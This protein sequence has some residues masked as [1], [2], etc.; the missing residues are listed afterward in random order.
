MYAK[1]QQISVLL[2]CLGNI[3]R[4]PMAEG[5]LR[6]AAERAGLDIRVDSAGTAA[7]H[8]GDPPD[9]RAVATAKAHG[10]NISSLR[11]RQLIDRD[12]ESFTHIIA[13]DKANMAGIKARAPRH[14]DFKLSLLLDALEEH[15]GEPVP[16][17][18][19]GDDEGFEECWQIIAQAVDALVEKISV[20][21]G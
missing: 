21:R 20:Q 1:D 6:A 2:V 13:L 4:S 8:I 18:Y 9:P 5:A 12:F 3:C 7:Y 15:E 16:D 11:A 17:P 14:G 10:V 19:Y